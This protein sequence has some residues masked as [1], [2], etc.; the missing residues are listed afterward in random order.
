MNSKEFERI[1]AKIGSECKDISEISGSVVVNRFRSDHLGLIASKIAAAISNGNLRNTQRISD[2]TLLLSICLEDVKTF[3]LKFQTNNKDLAISIIKGGS[4]CLEFIKHL[5]Q[6]QHCCVLLD[7]DVVISID[8]GFSADCDDL[9]ASLPNILHSLFKESDK[10]G[11]Y[12]FVTKTKTLIGKQIALKKSYA[13][14]RS[15]NEDVTMKSDDLIMIKP[16]GRGGFSTV[17]L[18]KFRGEDVAVKV[19]SVESSNITIAEFQHEADLMRRLSNKNIVAYYGIT[20]IENGKVSGHCMIMEYLVNDSLFSYIKGNRS[21]EISWANKVDIAIDVASGI[22]FLHR[23]RIIHRDIKL[24]NILL[25]EHLHAKVADFGLSF[26]KN[27]NNSIY[28]MNE[29]G[30]IPYMVLNKLILGSRM[31]WYE[32]LI[33]Y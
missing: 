30:T 14:K 16:V 10:S 26:A 7:F 2:A 19:L 21:N 28:T 29:G 24:G 20:E 15:R 9:L 6:L 12:G 18:G 3:L 23:L 11:L 17:W 32:G 13:S 31:F 33:L 5:E 27:A 8:D 4:F 1:I 22:A 25:N